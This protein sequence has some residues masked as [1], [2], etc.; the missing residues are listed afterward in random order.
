MWKDTLHLHFIVFLWGFT[1]ILGKLISLDSTVI[2]CYRTT[3]SALA[4]AIIV[5]IGKQKIKV[6]K[7]SALKIILTGFIV[8]L[9]WILFFA[10]AKLS[11]S[12]C[13]AG[14][15]TVTLFTSILEPVIL[16]SKLKWYEVMLG[17]FVIAGLYTIYQFEYE[18]SYALIL[19]LISA[20]LA[21]LFSILNKKFTSTY[22]S[23]SITYYE[24]I[25]ASICSLI[26]IPVYSYA[27]G[28]SL[29][30]MPTFTDWGY[31]LVLALVCTVYAFYYSVQILR[32]MSAFN[33]NLI[34]NLEPVYGIILALL[35]FQESEE[36]SRQFYLG[37]AMIVCSVFLYPYLEKKF[38]EKKTLDS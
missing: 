8:S 35:I 30:I 7:K 22:S 14:I 21:A 20:F 11:V 13:L 33:V 6:S 36:M 28:L 15:A 18:Y 5:Q 31:L 34:I 27:S 29:E 10:A 9:H 26:A 4:I 1:S 24:M 12:I 32:K 23:L 16:K 17:L 19:S 3:I 25:G 38:G 2:V 37:T